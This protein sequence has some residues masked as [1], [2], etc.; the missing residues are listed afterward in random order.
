MTR[1]LLP[2]LLLGFT[3]F[4]GV[5]SFSPVIGPQGVN[6]WNLD[7][8]EARERGASSRRD[9]PLESKALTVQSGNWLP[10]NEAIVSARAFEEFEPQWFEQPLDHFDESNPHTFKQRYWVSKRHYKARQGAPVFVLDGGE[11]SGAVRWFHDSERN[12][13]N[14]AKY[15]EQ[16]ALPRHR[17]RRYPCSRN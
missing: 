6:F 5:N 16:A 1:F 14:R 11:T 4:T 15:I 3:S 13:V 2:L 17:H 7:K 12:I 8:Q 10:D 9:L